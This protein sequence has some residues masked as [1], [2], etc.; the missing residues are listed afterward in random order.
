[1]Q[2]ADL[3]PDP[4]CIVLGARDDGVALVVEGAREDLVNVPLEYLQALAALGGPQPARLVAACC[5]QPIPLRVERYLSVPVKSAK[6]P[7]AVAPALLVCVRKQPM[8]LCLL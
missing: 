5:D 8:L 2:A 1:V 6:D 7:A 3:L 4:A